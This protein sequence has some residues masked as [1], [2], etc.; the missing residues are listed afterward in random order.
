MELEAFIP[1]LVGGGVV[2]VAVVVAVTSWR[3][4]K[5]RR[6]ALA[7]LAE[8][9]GYTYTPDGIDLGPLQ[10]LH[11]FA[12]G[13]SREGCNVL[14]GQEAEIGVTIFDYAYV[15][16][17][18]KNRRT[19]RQT[20]V[21]LRWPAWRLPQFAL[22]PENVLHKI[23]GL[24]GFQDIDLPQAPEFSRLFLLRGPVEAAVRQVFNPMVVDFFQR[25]AGLSAEGC[26]ADLVLYRA[27][28]RL[29]VEELRGMVNEALDLAQ[30][31][32]RGG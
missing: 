30:R 8:Q 28:R 6:E 1:F 9:L 3:A 13:R 23:G 14:R 18:G 16:G 24:F 12:Q 31:W 11:L 29:R 32:P 25:R 19:S 15:I 27:D 17:S 21:W 20:V 10:G 5:Q 4:E 22:R 7:A 26:G 2:L